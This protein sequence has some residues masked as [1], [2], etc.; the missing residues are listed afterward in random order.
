MKGLVAFCSGAIVA[1]LLPWV[2][3]GFMAGMA[4]AGSTNAAYFFGMLLA[5]LLVPALLL[6]IGFSCGRLI[7][8]NEKSQRFFFLLGVISALTALGF[9]YFFAEIFQP[10]TAAGW[11]KTLLPAFFGVG[12]V[13]PAVTVRK[14]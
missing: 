10:Q 1:L 13:A 12:F 4:A 14:G 5:I 6:G 2:L 8:S 7:F 9:D 3:L 11:I